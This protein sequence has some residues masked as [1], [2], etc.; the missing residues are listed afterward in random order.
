M[1]DF[2]SEEPKVQS[3]NGGRVSPPLEK[4]GSGSG[5]DAIT[6]V[7]RSI[8]TRIIDSFRRDPNQHVTERG[9]IIDL[10]VRKSHENHESDSYDVE[11]AMAN[12][13]KAPLARKL[14]S[15]HLQMIAIGGAIG[16]YPRL[17]FWG[18]LRKL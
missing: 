16:I 8:P 4:A 12:L 13:A 11:S 18:E 15:R 9:E 14:A 17:S 7:R 6:T 2:K 3:V 5:S 1:S 10:N